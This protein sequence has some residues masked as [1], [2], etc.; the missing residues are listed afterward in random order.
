MEF[1][2]LIGTRR[3]IRYFEPDK[4]VEMEKIQ[5]ILEA[6]LVSSCAVNAHWLKAVVVRREDVSPD[7]LEKMKLPV[8]AAIIEMAP[9]QIYFYGDPAVVREIKGSRLKE[10]VDKGALNPTHGWSHKFV[11]E[12][13]YPQILKPLTENPAYPIALSFD[14]GVSACQGLLMAFDLGLGACLTA[15]VADIVKKYTKVPDHWIPFYVLNVGYRA[16]SKE[17]GGQRPRPPFEG[18]YF[19]GQFGKPFPRDPKVVEEL[20]RSKVLQSPAML[21][22]R[23]EE[24]RELARRLGLPE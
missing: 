13:V 1:Q 17:A 24:V 11:D 2:E 21:P 20:R 15:Y 19:L 14:C 23:K 3:S 22:G 4:P 6:C 8:Q 16:E 18:Q 5:K 10:L 7:D 12:V 9:V